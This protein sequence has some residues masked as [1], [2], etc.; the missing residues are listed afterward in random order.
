MPSADFADALACRLARIAESGIA[1]IS[2]APKTGVGILKI[3]FRFPPWPVSGFPAGRKSNWEI[4]H[5]GASARPVITK[6]S[7]T[8]PSAL[9]LLFLNRASRIGPFGA[10]NHGTAFLAPFKAATSGKGFFAGLVPPI[11]GC[12][13][14]EKH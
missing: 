3:I 7:C 6:R 4:L 13:W 10:M 1:S 14:Q 12:E 9:P 5:P 11:L 2:P 8:P